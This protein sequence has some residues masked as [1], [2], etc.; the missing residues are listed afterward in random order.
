M[1]TFRTG[2]S[3][4]GESWPNPAPQGDTTMWNYDE[5]TGLLLSKVYADGYG[6]ASR[7]L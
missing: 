1:T 4:N 3:W 6:P 5:A 7:G 2:N